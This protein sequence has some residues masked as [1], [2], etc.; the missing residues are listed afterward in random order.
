MLFEAL[1]RQL[2]RMTSWLFGM[3]FGRFVTLVLTL[4]V[5]RNGFWFV[6]NIE[7]VRLISLDPAVCHEEIRTTPTAH[8]LMNSFL[9]PLLAWLLHANRDN[10]VFALAHLALFLALFP[11]VLLLAR[12]R[13][14]DPFAR[15]LGIAFAVLPTSTVLFTWLG[16]ADVFTV[17]L[18]SVIFLAESPLLL[19]LA[20]LLLGVNHF[21]QGAILVV[22]IVLARWFIAGAVTAPRV[23]RLAWA[24]VGLVLGKLALKGW[25]AYCHIELVEGRL[26]WVILTGLREFTRKF[27]LNASAVL[28]SLF[29]VFWAAIVLLGYGIA[30]KSP[31]ALAGLA[32]LFV[33]VLG[34]AV[35]TLD[36]TRVFA[37][38]SWPVVMAFLLLA[39]AADPA[40]HA[41]TRK[42]LTAV[43]A[44][45]VV[46][47]PL[48][49]WA[50]NIHS[51]LQYHTVRLVYAALT[52]GGEVPK[53]KS[54]EPSF[55]FRRWSPYPPRD[56][57][58]PDDW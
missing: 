13:F 11:L 45:A 20:G 26:D 48:F 3:G 22:L 2:D 16:N 41:A 17:L 23:W 51:G 15:G 46:V 47:P 50:A 18:T 1:S 28:F 52:N 33:L 24:A 5:L 53:E 21:E 44:A 49:V 10:L 7:Y 27:L 55:P 40:P 34:V 36:L 57:P 35:L 32:A 9:G 25:F 19:L 29:N 4:A 42:V 31:R 14:G 6:P 43:L 58:S 56:R 37:L 39:L 30:R 12:R 8:Y 54:F 38:L